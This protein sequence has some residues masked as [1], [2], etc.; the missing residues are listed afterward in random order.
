VRWAFAGGLALF[1]LLLLGHNLSLFTREIYEDSDYAANS[2][3]IAR[4]KRLGLLV[5][6]YSRV[7][8]NHPGPGILYVLAGAELLL[9][10]LLGV[11][12]TPHNAHMLGALLFDAVLL[13]LSLAVLHS[14]FRS[15][16]ATAAAAAAFL[17][18][19]ALSGHLAKH[20]MP[21]LYF[22]PFLLLLVSTAS[23][24]CGQARHLPWLALAGGLLVHGHVCFVAFA[25][26]LGLYA[27]LRLARDHGYAVRRLLRLHAGSFDAFAAL[28]ALFLLPITL[29]TLWHYPGEVGK[30]LT[31]V[32]E[33]GH[34]HD[35]RE[36]VPFMVGT[37]T[38]EAAHP[39]PIVLGVLG[40]VALTL[41]RRADGPRRRYTT[42]ALA[43]CGLATVLMFYYA[44][45]GVDSLEHTYT[46]IF[47]GSVLLL[48]GALAALNAVV[49]F[50]VGRRRRAALACLAGL[51]GLAAAGTGRFT[52][53]YEGAPYLVEV[54]TWLEG[55]EEAD[56]P[57]VVTHPLH[58]WPAVVGLLVHLERRGQRAFVAA[59]WLEFLYTPHY[60]RGWEDLT[61][62]RYLDFAFPSER[63]G[64]VRHVV[65]E[66]DDLSIRE[67]DRQYRPGTE[68]SF[69]GRDW[70]VF[71]GRGWSVGADSDSPPTVGPEACLRLE[72][73]QPLA[74]DALLSVTARSVGPSPPPSLRVDVAVNGQPVAAWQ[75]PGAGPVR[76]QAPVPAAIL[77][78][79]GPVE[80]TFRLSP[81]RPA[82]TGP[83]PDP[84]SLALSL[85]KLC[86]A[87]KGGR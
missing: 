87:A 4:A 66:R 18:Y 17:G 13:A 71:R 63:G 72:L 53:R 43:A 8:F 79:P 28:V 84:G 51:A 32:R 1:G 77:N 24:A 34:W 38:S 42:Q 55:G 58:H 22:A 6:N 29:H 46:G 10:D 61:G 5:G 36:V 83:P 65:Y 54:A 57:V 52:N 26:P 47:F 20:W 81:G 19:F 37:L 23:V 12:P 2:I 14:H 85:R 56:R 16:L 31:Y 45:K 78:R 27:L 76:L 3:L 67:L 48:L 44:S 60:T 50:G 82:G 41:P 35:P 25:V 80:I 59:P 9:Y 21:Y 39:W 86:L 70:T 64:R 15:G 75:V 73:K 40:A 69:G 62:A 33:N 74:G 11:V 7:Q 49:R 68:L 30:Y